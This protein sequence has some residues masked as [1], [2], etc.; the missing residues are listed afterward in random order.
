MVVNEFAEALKFRSDRIRSRRDHAKY[1]NLIRVIALLHQH[2][3]EIKT[4]QHN[5]EEIEYIEVT[6]SDIARADELAA[7][8]LAGSYEDLPE[9]TQFVLKTIHELLVKTCDEQ[10]IQSK[11]F[12]FNPS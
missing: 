2:Q 3:R 9:R 10:A 12:R 5:G 7:A 4:V 11:D 1:L 8:V 6:Q